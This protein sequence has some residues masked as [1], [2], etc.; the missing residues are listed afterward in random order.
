MPAENQ[1]YI[2]ESVLKRFL[3]ED[4]K[5]WELNKKANHVEHR[6]TGKAGAEPNIY[7]S[8]VERVHMQKWDND[9][10]RII[11]EKIVGQRNI[12]L[13]PTEV[14]SLEEWLLIF[15]LRVPSHREICDVVL[16]AKKYNRRKERLKILCDRSSYISNFRKD[17][18]D[19]YQKLVKKMGRAKADQLIVSILIQRNNAGVV[20]ASISGERIFHYMLTSGHHTT[21]LKAV[22]GMKWRWLHTD[23]EFIIGDNPLCRTRHGYTTRNPTGRTIFNYG[24]QQRD[25][26]ITFPMSKCL[27]LQMDRLASNVTD[28]D[29][30]ES[31]AKHL[32]R[33]QIA[34]AGLKA[35]GPSVT[36]LRPDSDGTGFD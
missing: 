23:Q 1:H 8:D 33:M 6:A 26:V 2:P 16:K 4:G 35:R 28:I 10:N 13:T 14:K 29:I 27:C 12:Q 11:Q 22:K 30:S 21:H 36:A 5:L 15:I 17:N 34:G 25:I 9:A 20:E 24:L 3:D 19:H 32:N 7:P 31:Q 18:E